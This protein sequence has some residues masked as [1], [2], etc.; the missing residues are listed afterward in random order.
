VCEASHAGGKVLILIDLREVLSDVLAV[1][2]DGL[3]DAVELT[4]IPSWNSLKHIELVVRLEET[5]Q[6]ELTQD[7]IVEMTSVSAIRLVL[8]RHG[9]ALD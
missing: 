4:E 9:V 5:Y 1:P 7:D 8:H 6:L 2:P 3:D